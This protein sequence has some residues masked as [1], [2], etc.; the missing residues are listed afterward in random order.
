MSLPVSPLHTQSIQPVCGKCLDDDLSGCENTI[1][2][3]LWWMSN[4]PTT[5]TVFSISKLSLWL[6]AAQPCL[7]QLKYQP[8]RLHFK[9][10]GK[11]YRQHTWTHTRTQPKPLLL[12]YTAGEGFTQQ[13]KSL[14]HSDGPNEGVRG[15]EESP[16]SQFEQR[17]DEIT[18]VVSAGL[19][20]EHRDGDENNKTSR[21]TVCL[22]THRCI[23]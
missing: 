9:V 7:L 2:C 14:Q 19:T 22:L 10:S 8:G 6:S 11:P 12:L 20:N 3:L 23:H 16:L 21:A 15:R 18:Q 4:T 13:W 17:G 1:S 5:H